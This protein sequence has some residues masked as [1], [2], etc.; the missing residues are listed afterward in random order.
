MRYVLFF[1][2][3]G[4]IGFFAYQVVNEDSSFFNSTVSICKL[5]ESPKQYAKKPEVTIKGEVTSSYS[6]FGKNLYELTQKN[7]DCSIR[8]VSSGASPKEGN[9]LTVTGKLKEAFKI[10]NTRMLVVLE[11]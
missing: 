11:E 4:L 1:V 7:E 3:L 8:V 2:I 6:L 9:I 5:R 10:G